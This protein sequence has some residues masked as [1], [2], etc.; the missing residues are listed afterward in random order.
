MIAIAV[1]FIIWVKMNDSKSEADG[2]T[3]QESRT[4]ENR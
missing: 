3:E 1:A 4:A 2:E